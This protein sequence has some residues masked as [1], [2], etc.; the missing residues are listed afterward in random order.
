MIEIGKYNKL[1][2]IRH[3]PPGVYLG[4]DN[5]EEV[6]LL[7]NKYVPKDLEEGQE[8]DVFIYKD[9]LD[10]IVATTLEPKIKLHE[11]GCLEVVDVNQFGAFLDWG[12]EKHLMVPYKE[13]RKTMRPG[14]YHLV[15]LLLDNVS[16]RL[17]AT[18]KIDRY[19]EKENIEV[20]AGD[21]VDL[22]IGE[23][24]ETGITVIINNKYKGLLYHNEVF[25][26]IFPG[27]R[28]EGYIKQ[29]REDNKI[30][31]S[32]QQQG[33][34]NI[35]PSAD[36]LLEKLKAN[37]GFLYLTD[38]SDPEDIMHKMQMSKKTF[39]KAVG[40]LYKQRMIT[41]DE[42]GIRLVQEDSEGH[43]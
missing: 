38:K 39:K 28:T 13:Q 27:D 22:L 18:T 29:V 31:V 43:R 41:I 7:P 19:L 26:K 1:R 34:A 9:S 24:T 35:D 25:R 40:V 2:A 10:D 37:G 17:L 16:E 20:E 30:D 36:V 8:I 32:L 4:K 12:L 33:F 5:E 3:T 14:E 21:K 15:Y 6:V 42:D 23:S 11:F